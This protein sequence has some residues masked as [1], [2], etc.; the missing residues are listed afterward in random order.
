MPLLSDETQGLLRSGHVMVKTPAGTAMAKAVI[1]HEPANLYWIRA[2]VAAATYDHFPKLVAIRTNTVA[3]RQVQTVRGEVLGGSNGAPDQT[4]TIANSPVLAESLKIQIDQ[5]SGYETWKRVDDF[6]SSSKSDPHYVLNPA[7]GVVRFGDG[8]NGAI[9]TANLE[10]PNANVVAQQY[11]Y[12]GGTRGNVPAGA[13]KTPLT[14][15]TGI[16]ESKVSN[17]LVAT[18]G[19]DEQSIDDAKKRAPALLRSNHRAV[20]A[21]DFEELAKQVGAVRR[22]KAVPLYHPRFPGVAIPGVVTVI[23]VPD[24]ALDRPT[25]SQETLNAVCAYLNQRRL[26]TTEVYVIAPTYVSVQVEVS[27]VAAVTADAA[28]L[29]LAIEGGIKTYFHP[30][31]GGDDNL[32]WPFGGTIFFSKVYQ[33]VLSIPGVERVGTLSIRLEGDL[34]LPCTDV[35]TPRTALLYSLDH[36][37]NV[38]YGTEQ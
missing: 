3:A 14:S 16:D 28:Q 38:T 15:L 30:L 8:K 10:N 21:G 25:P 9:P 32:G 34:A 5:G 27:V 1:G 19:R 2:R 36:K 33:Q 6:F 7:T 17:L 23:V 4:F 18:G 13:I 12:G 20:T 31:R 11:S 24:N 37:A 22:A 35:A 26:L 29:K